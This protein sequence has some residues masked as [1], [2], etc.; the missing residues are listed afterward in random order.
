MPHASRVSS[1]PVQI[2]RDCS[3]DGVFK[4]LSND[5]G[6]P[7]HAH[8]SI[9]INLACGATISKPGPRSELLDGY[10][11]APFVAALNRFTHQCTP[12]IVQTSC[13]WQTIRR[14]SERLRPPCWTL[15]HIGS[16]APP[17]M[18]PSS[19]RRYHLN[20]PRSISPCCPGMATSRG[21]SQSTR[22]QNR[23]LHPLPLLPTT[24]SSTPN[25]VLANP[26]AFCPHAIGDAVEEPIQ[27][28]PATLSI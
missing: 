26:G 27:S 17:P 28:R 22:D 2:L 1:I 7:Q 21:A 19:P 4:Y 9:I 15:S 13:P 25:S 16:R 3:P 14:W 10:V 20:G 24:T 8:K 11:F 12:V 6:T 18:T 5:D 23:Q